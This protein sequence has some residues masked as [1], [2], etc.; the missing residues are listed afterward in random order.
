METLFDR[1]KT[2][3]THAV[4]QAAMTWLDE[5]GFKPVE[6]EVEIARGW[7][8]DL[9]SAIFPTPTE[10]INL[11]LIPHRPDWEAEDEIQEA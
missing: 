8:A 2:D 1:N 3:L 10:L 4:T 5:R 11:K 7:V 9:A 6:T